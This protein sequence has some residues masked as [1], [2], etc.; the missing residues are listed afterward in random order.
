[1]VLPDLIYTLSANYDLADIATVGMAVTGQTS[2]IDSAGFE[3]PGKAIFNP[4]VRVYPI[5][6]LE[7]GLQ[8][9]NLFDTFDLRG[10]GGIADASVN[11]TVIGG[12]PA[13]GRTISA[14]VRYNF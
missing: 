12:A 11:P 14:S 4:S 5:Q 9:Y 10:N 8:V 6:N 13:L 7:L 3:Y 1:M 2:A